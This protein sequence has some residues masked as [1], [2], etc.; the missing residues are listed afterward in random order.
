MTLPTSL[1]FCKLPL[2][3]A[4]AEPGFITQGKISYTFHQQV[5]V[6]G[7]HSSSPQVSMQRAK[8]NQHPPAHHEGWMVNGEETV[9]LLDSRSLTNH[10][11]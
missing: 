1:P 3:K 11:G 6:V 8:V 9:F 7:S 5:A 4:G 10:G 2:C